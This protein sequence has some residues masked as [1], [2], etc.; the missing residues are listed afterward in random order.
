MISYQRYVTCNNSSRSLRKAIFVII[1]NFR[2]RHPLDSGQ[3][4]RPNSKPALVSSSEK[5]L[6][7]RRPLRSRPLAHT[8][9]RPYAHTP[10]VP[11]HYLSV[12]LTGFGPSAPV[13]N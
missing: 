4:L 5:G 10:H 13:K 6:R 9:T 12:L 7:N 1:D 3:T 8:P 2:E 11:P